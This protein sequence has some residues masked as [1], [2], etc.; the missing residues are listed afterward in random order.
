MQGVKVRFEL[1]L[2]GLVNV[3]RIEAQFE[4]P[5]EPEED[6]MLKKIG[7]SIG[8]GSLFGDGKKDAPADD[9]EPIESGESAETEADTDAAEKET[10]ST[11]KAEKEADAKAEANTTAS[12]TTA[13]NTT[14][15]TNTTTPV[16]PEAKKDRTVRVVLGSDVESNDLQLLSGATY[17]AAKLRLQVLKV[18]VTLVACYGCLPSFSS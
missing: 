10:A 3:S 4:G 15:T 11:E 6:S 7:D 16:K 18:L 9:E 1:D 2:S 13:G 14:N 12:N 8:L 17:E 5:E